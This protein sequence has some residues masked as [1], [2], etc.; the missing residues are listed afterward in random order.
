MDG[1]EGELPLVIVKEMELNSHIAGFHVYK[2]VWEPYVG[3][4]LQSEMEPTNAVDKYSVCV[5]KDNN[6]IAHIEKG[7]SGD[8]QKLLFILCVLTC[9]VIVTG[10]A[11][12]LGDNKGVII[13]G[14]KYHVC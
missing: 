10:N 8:L 3:D 7:R 14:K 6:I 13:R 12:N 4:Q 5:K 11:V 1:L 9:D 2:T